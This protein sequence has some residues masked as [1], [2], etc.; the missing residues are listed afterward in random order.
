M[1]SLMTPT[2]A[3]IYAYVNLDS[4]DLPANSPED[5]VF[6]HAFGQATLGRGGPG[7]D[8]LALGGKGLGGIHVCEERTRD[9]AIF[10]EFLVPG[11]LSPFSESEISSA[12]TR[13][14]RGPTATVA[15]AKAGDPCS[16]EGFG[17]RE[18]WPGAVSS[19]SGAMGV[20][21]DAS[22]AAKQRDVPGIPP[23]E[24][25]LALGE[26]GKPPTSQ[27][28][29]PRR[30]GTKRKVRSK[31]EEALK[32][33]EFLERNRMAAQKCRSK[34]KYTTSTLE[35]NLA[36]QEERNLRLKAEVGDLTAEIGRWREVYAQCEKECR[37]SRSGNAVGGEE[38]LARLA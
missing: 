36:A 29:R 15:S 4:A 3:F 24:A 16:A 34:K 38:E 18:A 37:E 27:E 26:P 19:S 22:T 7:S 5:D 6:A 1:G 35:E 31:D 20:M 12:G 10:G 8:P 13:S 32:R 11:S 33:K 23:T 9:T 25:R 21:G 30:R 17:T 28:K 2:T 14:S